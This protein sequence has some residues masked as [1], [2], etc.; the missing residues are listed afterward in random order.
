MRILIVG[1]TGLI[2]TAITRLLVARGDDVTLYNRGVTESQMASGLERIRGDRTEYAAFEAQMAEAGSFDCVIDMVCYKPEEAESAIRAFQGRIGQYIFC[3]TVDVYTK[4]AQRYPVQ[5]DAERQPA[6]SF[7]Y[8]F[9]KAACERVLESAHQRGEFPVTVIRPAHTYGEGGGLIHTLG[10]RT[11]YLDRVR[12]GKPIIVHG[13]GTSFWATCH[14][15]D[16]GRAFV[17]A[18]GNEKAFGQAYHAAGEE[19][20]TWDAYHQGVAEAMGAPEPILVHIP[21]DLLGKVAPKA[22]KWCVENFHFN[23]VFDNTA[24]K[25]DL[26]FQ[27]TIPWVAGARRTVA[28]LDEHGRIEDSDHHPFY[29]QIIAAWNQLSDRL[30]QGLASLDL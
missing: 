7:P 19:P 8:A 26:G 2:S 9:G 15:D 17:G 12:K 27:Q 21:T 25:T 10:W 3:S 24:A 22:A 29:D 13:D 30:T 1:G 5:E 14:R 11:Y 28:W 18:V 6:R 20:M 4:P 23:N 16:V